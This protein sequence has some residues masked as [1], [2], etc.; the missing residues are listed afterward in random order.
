MDTGTRRQTEGL[1]QDFQTSALGCVGGVVSPKVSGK[2]V[3]AEHDWNALRSGDG[4]AMND[5]TG[6]C[7]R[8]ATHSET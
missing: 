1:Q 7:D 2:Q 3:G 5:Y 6:W 8:E 4:N